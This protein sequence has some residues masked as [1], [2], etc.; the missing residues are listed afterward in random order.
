[1]AINRW[2]PMRDFMTLREAMDRLFEDSLVNWGRAGMAAPAERVMR[3]PIDAYVTD[4][5]IVILAPV[6][7]VQPEDVEISLEGDTLT[8]KGEIKPPLEN[9]SYV[10]QERAYGPFMRTLTL[11]VPV[12]AEK[13]E[14]TFENGMLTLTIPKAESVKPKTIKVKTK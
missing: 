10:F 13:A 8:I 14:A 2:E 5:E 11:N 7:G 9:V 3:L 1:M 6:P 12:E 4:N